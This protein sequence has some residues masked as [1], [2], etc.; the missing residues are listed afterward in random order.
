M[1][2][3]IGLPQ[4]ALVD[5]RIPKR[6]LLEHGAPTAADKRLLN[7]GVEQLHWVATLKPTTVGVAAYRDEARE[8]LEVSVLRVVLA[9]GAKT[10][11]LLELVHRAIPYPVFAIS[12]SA[13]RVE[14]SLAHKR[15]SQG[16]IGKV[17]L[18][19]AVVAVD[20]PGE[21]APHHDHFVAALPL[22]SQPHS[23][24][25]SVYQ[26]W[27]GVLLA[28]HAARRTGHFSLRGS[29]AEVAARQVALTECNRLETEVARLRAAAAK[30][31]QIP[32]Q[33]ELNLDLKRA[34]AALA[35]AIGNL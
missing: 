23:S 16:E 14:I 31:K 19:G 4:A 1:I 27:V 29:S 18:D 35:A 11:R 33:V 5:R 6:L 7:S 2:G 12:K 30:E 20:C 25:L 26:G 8:Y 34:E 15:W 10:S 22:A 3:A 32:R 9:E 17:V 24:L 13:A 21:G 28:L